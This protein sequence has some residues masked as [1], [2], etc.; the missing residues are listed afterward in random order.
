MTSEHSIIHQV[1]L[2]LMIHVLLIGI[3]EMVSGMF[4][5]E[6]ERKKGLKFVF[7]WYNNLEV[8]MET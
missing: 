1:F 3:P 8:T 6:L 7:R 2:L 4:A 5:G